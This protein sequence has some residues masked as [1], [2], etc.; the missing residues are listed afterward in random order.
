M[1]S[2]TDNHT[3]TSSD[4]DD[5]STAI[6]LA[7]HILTHYLWIV[8]VVI[9]VPGN[10]ITMIVATRK[11]NRNLS[12]STYMSAMALA[13]LTELVQMGWCIPLLNTE[14]GNIITERRDLLF[15]YLNFLCDHTHIMHYVNSISVM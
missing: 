3:A 12:P 1:S 14:L 13:D 6:R 5:A 7:Y 8:P 2:T 11:N 9:G 15:K 4:L 10:V